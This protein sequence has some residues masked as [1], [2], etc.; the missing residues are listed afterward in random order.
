MERMDEHRR[1]KATTIWDL[2]IG[3]K[4]L[5]ERK[6]DGQTRSTEYQKDNGHDR[7]KPE[8]VV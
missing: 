1:A 5:G 7:Q 6:P 4:R 8:R 2:R 3:E